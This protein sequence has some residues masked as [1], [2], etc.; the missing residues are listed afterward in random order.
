MDTAKVVVRRVY[1][2]LPLKDCGCVVQANALRTDWNDVVPAEQCDYI[3]GNPPFIGYSNL[4]EGQKEDRSSIFGKDG[5]TLDYVACWYK[6][7]A[8]YTKSRRIRCAF[9]ST[10]SICQGQ[11]VEPLWKPLFDDGIHID[12]AHQTFVWNSEATN[13]AHVHVVI[14]GFSNDTSSTPPPKVLFNGS[15]QGRRVEHIN[16]Y[17]APAPD[18][19][20]TKRKAPVC[21]ALP[22]VRGCNQPM[23]GPCS[24]P[25]P[26]ATTC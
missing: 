21:N 16:A 24:S 7:A 5:G 2:E 26:S 14:V 23:T 25:R 22:M 13:E 18:A 20:V 19:F 10:N 3:I 17:L 15:G 12:F 6:K 4:T 8:D 9:V 1:D 11:Q